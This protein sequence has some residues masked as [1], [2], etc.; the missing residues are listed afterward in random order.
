LHDVVDASQLFKGLKNGESLQGFLVYV[1]SIS[2]DQDIIVKAPKNLMPE[3]S[4]FFGVC[5]RRKCGK[6]HILSIWIF[7]G[8]DQKGASPRCPLPIVTP[9]TQKGLFCL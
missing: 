9:F 6:I 8:F 4:T 7:F 1:A 5:I 3:I 2:E